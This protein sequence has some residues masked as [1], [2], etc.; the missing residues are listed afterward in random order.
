MVRLAGGEAL[1]LAD[2]PG[3]GG[4]GGKQVREGL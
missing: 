3:A 2:P 1:G 4:G